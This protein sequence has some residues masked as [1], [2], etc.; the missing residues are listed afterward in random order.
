MTQVFTYLLTH[1]LLFCNISLTRPHQYCSVLLVLIWNIGN[2]TLPKFG[3]VSY[4]CEACSQGKTALILTLKRE[5]RHPVDGQFGRVFPAICNHCRVMTAWS[6]KTW[7]FCEHFLRFFRKTTPY[8]KVFK[9]IF[10]KVYITTLIDVVCWNVVK[11]FGREIAEIMR[12]LPD[13]TKFWLPVK[14]S[15]LRGSCQKSARACPQHLA[16]TVSDLI[17]IG[18]LS[19]EL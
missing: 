2:R 6:R 18:L 1:N 13:K 19:A 8:G 3:Q 17:Q 9:K 12:C 16:H 15:V 5:S 7:K 10:L 11:F 4:L 14:L